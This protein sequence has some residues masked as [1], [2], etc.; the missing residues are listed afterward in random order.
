MIAINT[1]SRATSIRV[2]SC[3]VMVTKLQLGLKF[4]IKYV[5]FYILNSRND[6]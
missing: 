4:N 2:V 1:K 3:V 5:Y 6:R